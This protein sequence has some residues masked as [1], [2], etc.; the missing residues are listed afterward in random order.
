MFQKIPGNV[1]KDSRESKFRFVLWNLAYF[2]SNSAIKLRKNKGI[3]SALLIT[4]YNYSPVLKYCFSSTFFFL[5]F[6]L[7]SRKWCNYC[8]QVQGYQKTL[9]NPQLRGLKNM[10][11]RVGTINLKLENWI[12][13]IIAYRHF[14]QNQFQKFNSGP[15]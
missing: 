8:A 12:N 2:L 5:H 15:L 6:F 1:R 13:A 4:T 14:T 7:L 10:L 9:N 11:H 3:F